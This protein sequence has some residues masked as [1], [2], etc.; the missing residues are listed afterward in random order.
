MTYCVIPTATLH[1]M[2]HKF[3]TLLYEGNIPVDEFLRWFSI[4]NSAY[5]DLAQCL[6]GILEV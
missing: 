5:I 1:P 3:L 4:V 2:S 6:V